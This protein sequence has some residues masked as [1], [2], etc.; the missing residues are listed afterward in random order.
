[1][2]RVA[3][4]LCFIPLACTSARAVDLS[5]E[6]TQALRDD[7]P[8]AREQAA[9]RIV[10][11]G[12]AILPAV[13]RLSTDADPDV[14]SWARW[15]EQEIH[16]RDI[17]ALRGKLHVAGWAGA[18]ALKCAVVN[19]HEED[20]EVVLFLE[21][22][23]PAPADQPGERWTRTRT[24]TAEANSVTYVNFD[25]A[26]SAKLYLFLYR[27]HLICEAYALS[28][29]KHLF[30]KNLP[31][32][33][34]QALK[35]HE[36][37]EVSAPEGFSAEIRGPVERLKDR[38]D[39][40]LH[41]RN[42]ESCKCECRSSAVEMTLTWPPAKPVIRQIVMAKEEGEVVVRFYAPGKAAVGRL[43]FSRIHQTC[44]DGRKYTEGGKT[45]SP[46][47]VFYDADRMKVRI[48]E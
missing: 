35:K 44:K 5:T 10:A 8:R 2:R 36:T 33:H 37:F 30:S 21:C 28:E 39:V 34:R 29:D 48:Q 13:R 4:L 12:P 25:P 7:D 32:T 45:G 47:C 19:T 41:V 18:D 17:E 46:D 24:V 15:I 16:V 26:E 31:L 40:D 3:L 22:A 42:C 38:M 14:R 23:G 11:M 43:R 9:N 20:H 6:L 27:P 1:M